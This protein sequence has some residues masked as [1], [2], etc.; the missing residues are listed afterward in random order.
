[1]Q[2]IV[3]ARLSIVGALGDETF[4]DW[5]V[6]R[7]RR[8]SLAGGVR[9]ISPERI[10]ILVEGP[11]ALTDAMEMACSLGP[12]SVLVQRIER[13]SLNGLPPEMASSC[14]LFGHLPSS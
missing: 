6:E 13:A 10:E 9:R 1:M 4:P 3:A 8:L 14:T 7:G 12:A 11:E 5:I 2:R